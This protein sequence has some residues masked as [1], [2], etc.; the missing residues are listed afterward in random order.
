MRKRQQDQ[1][2]PE[3]WAA[4]WPNLFR[5]P[6][7]AE[8]LLRSPEWA[9]FLQDLRAKAADCSN[10]IVH[11]VAST[12]EHMAEQNLL[13]GRVAQCEEIFELGDILKRWKE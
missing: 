9:A 1:Q 5:D 13:R 3:G 12:N 4:A 10:D 2:E 6:E 11:H 8:A 7:L